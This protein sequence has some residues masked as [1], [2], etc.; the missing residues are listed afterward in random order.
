MIKTNDRIPAGTLTALGEVG[1]Q[2]FNPAELFDKGTHIL[3]AVPGAFTPTCSEKHLPGFVEHAAEL[4]KH[5]VQTIACVA[6]ND[7]FVMKA[8]GKALNVGDSVMLLSDGDASYHREL[9]LIK[10]TGSFGGT[11]AERYAM[12]ITDGVITH[13]FV[14]DEKS[15]GVSSAEHVLEALKKG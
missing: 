8:W 5:G 9:G 7:A 2:Q 11:R 13:L 3:F 4:K 1:M 10:E 14:E 15:Y 6:V 12:V